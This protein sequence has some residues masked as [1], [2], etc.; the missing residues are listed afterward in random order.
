YNKTV[1]YTGGTQWY[2]AFIGFGGIA[3]INDTE[4]CGYVSMYF[5][6]DIHATLN[7]WYEQNEWYKAAWGGVKWWN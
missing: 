1:V 6:K 2:S 7:K 4:N 3:Q 5:P